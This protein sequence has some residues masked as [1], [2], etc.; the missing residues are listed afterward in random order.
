MRRAAAAV[1][2]S[3]SCLCLRR[4][5]SGRCGHRGRRPQPLASPSVQAGRS[6]SCWRHLRRLGPRRGHGSIRRGG[7]RGRGRVGSRRGQSGVAATSRSDC[8]GGTGL[9]LGRFGFVAR[10][11]RSL[12]WP[13]APR[14][15]PRE[16]PPGPMSRQ[17][18]RGSV[19]VAGDSV[20]ASRSRRSGSVRYG[21]VRR[22]VLRAGVCAADVTS[23]CV[24][25]STASAPCTGTVCG[26]DGSG[27]A[28][29]TSG[30]PTSVA[31]DPPSRRQRLGP[32]RLQADTGRRRGGVA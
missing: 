11:P 19:G 31:R 21:P 5:R 7:R 13:S 14:H 28:G 25:G 1:G 20:Q 4:D 2:P 10:V 30:R 17:N 29:A 24:V 26:D 18:W 3:A 32:P 16:P 12:P 15:D 27:A 23:P 6:R 8:P 22:I 9:G